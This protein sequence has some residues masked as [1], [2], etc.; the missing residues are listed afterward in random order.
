M[1]FY[2]ARNS[3][4]CRPKKERKNYGKK[5]HTTTFGFHNLLGCF[6]FS[7]GE[8]FICPNMD[9]VKLHSLNDI[10]SFNT[11]KPVNDFLILYIYNPSMV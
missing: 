2:N 11:Q 7:S 10:T 4:R 1:I 6:F 3:V 9:V 8:C 5:I